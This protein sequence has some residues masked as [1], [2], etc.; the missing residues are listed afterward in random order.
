MR[1][2]SEHNPRISALVEPDAK[3]GVMRGKLHVY[4]T[5]GYD[6]VRAKHVVDKL[7]QLKAEGAKHLD[8]HLHS[9]GGDVHEGVAIHT[10]IAGW[11][12]GEKHVHVDGLAASIA[13]LIAM[14]GDR[15]TMAP[16]AMMML[17]NPKAGLLGL[18]TSDDLRKAADR[19][20]TQKSVLADCY[21]EA[22]GKSQDEILKM[23]AKETWLTADDA[24]KHGFADDIAGHKDEDDEE[25]GDDEREE[26]EEARFRAVATALYS[27]PPPALE[28]LFALNLPRFSPPP[29]TSP[30]QPPEA[31]VATFEELKVQI[32]TQTARA[33]TAE[34]AKSA[35]EKPVLELLAVTGQKTAGEALA[36]V[37]GLKEKAAQVDTLKAELAKRD[38]EA[39]KA[40]EAKKVE[41][42]KALFDGACK[43]GKLTPAKRAELEKPEAPAFAKDPVALKAFLDCLSPIVATVEHPVAEERPVAK[44]PPTV[45]L[46]EEDKK[47][48][49]ASNL[50]PVLFALE[51]A[52]PSGNL[53]REEMENRKKA[54]HAAAKAAKK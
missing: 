27:A 29:A 38:A 40:A 51:K 20:D 48:I 7:E 1:K 6:G 21:A 46:T 18:F 19:V 17:H 5:I 34:G 49:E 28:R 32:A 44:P 22:S 35:A 54:A 31:D 30:V 10:A 33:D 14:A 11:P 13:S 23:M 3:T 39:A 42:V 52:D 37:A 9:P 15:V 12:N 41:D 2:P 16:H 24:V 50:D 25:E 43:E 47:L 36:V 45:T 26:G 4:D 53:V 8:V